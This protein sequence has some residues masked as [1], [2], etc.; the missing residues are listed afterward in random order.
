M[1]K[2]LALMLC[3]SLIMPMIG[4]S[5]GLLPTLTDTYGIAMPTLINLFHRYPDSEEELADGSAVEYWASFTEADLNAF[6][7]LLTESGAALQDYS[8]DGSVFHATIAKEGSTFTLDFDTVQQNVTV[9][10]PAGTYDEILFDVKAVWFVAEEDEAAGRY[11]EAAA[12]YASLK[13][14]RGVTVPYRESDQ[15]ELRCYYEHGEALRAEQNWDDAVTAFTQAGTYSYAATQIR[16][17]RYAEGEAK[18]AARDWD[19]AVTAFTQAGTYSYAATQIRAT[20]YAE[21]EAKRAARDWDGAVTAF[22]QAG[23]YSDAAT[24][25]LATRY[26]EGEAKRAAQDWDGAVAAF[27]QAGRYSDV[28]TQIAETHYQHAAALYQDG[29]Y[30]DAYELYLQLAGYRDVDNLLATDDNLLAAAAAAAAAARIA[31]FRTV[32]GYVTFGR[33]EQDNNTTNGPEPIEWLVLDY[34]AANNRALLISRYG[35]D[36]KPYNTTYTNITWARCTLRSWLNNDFLNAAFSADERAAVLLTNVDNSKSQGH[37][38]YSTN[39]GSNTQDRIFLLSYAEFWR[40][41]TS[42]NARMCAPTAYAVANGAYTSSSDRVDGKATGLWWLRSPGYYPNFAANVS[43]DGGGGYNGV[44][45][46]AISVRPAFWI[47]LNSDLF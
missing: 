25:I 6:G 11:T 4:L 39:G 37:S 27:T 12:G 31:P 7:A 13:S 32:G 43:R 40:Y 1:K 29:S 42:K 44:G 46:E 34:D 15:A 21:G 16:A 10:Y 3:M 38:A 45:I 22:T 30:G 33:Y 26:A 9:T 18:R 2:L 24:Q 17:T 36:A 41:F 5:E 28:K 23:T 47:N 20:R 8:T 14:Y 35:L 19:G